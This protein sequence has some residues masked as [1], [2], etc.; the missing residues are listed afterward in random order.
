MNTPTHEQCDR[1]VV[2][3]ERIAAALERLARTHEEDRPLA[4]LVQQRAGWEHR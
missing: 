4:P 2:A 3:F 1:L